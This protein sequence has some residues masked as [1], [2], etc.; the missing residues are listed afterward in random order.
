MVVLRVRPEKGK[1]VPGW[2]GSEVCQS[3]VQLRAVFGREPAGM[4]GVIGRPVAAAGEAEA[5]TQRRAA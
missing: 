5:G 2:H 4:R 3:L 1:P